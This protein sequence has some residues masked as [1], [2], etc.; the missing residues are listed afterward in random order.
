MSEVHYV[1][2][3]DCIG[4][5]EWHFPCWHFL[6]ENDKN[7]EYLR[8]EMTKK[9][10]IHCVWMLLCCVYLSVPMN[11][12]DILGYH[13]HGAFKSF[14]YKIL[15]KKPRQR[16]G[17]LYNPH[18]VKCTEVALSVSSAHLHDIYLGH[19]SGLC[20]NT[21]DKNT[22]FSL[23]WKLAYPHVWGKHMWVLPPLFM[24]READEIIL[25]SLVFFCCLCPRMH[26]RINGMK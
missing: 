4:K 21:P 26:P 20:E 3:Q 17:Y 18:T 14:C 5:W 1:D 11:R 16:R 10:Q 7:K 2:N 12:S 15:K 23:S 25:A 8:T 13:C 24:L 6:P 9:S 22:D 19:S